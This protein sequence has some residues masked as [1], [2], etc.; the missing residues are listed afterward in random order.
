VFFLATHGALTIENFVLKVAAPLSP[1][2]LLGVRQFTEQ[3]DAS[4][5]LDKLK[6]HAER[7]WAD[8]LSGKDEAEMTARARGL[9]DEILENRR[10]GPL[11][12]DAIYKRLQRSYEAQMNHGI[13]ELVAEAKQTLKL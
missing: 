9:Q 1:A 11:V 2:L 12:L 3:M 7:L 13:A 8:A 10:G 6:E 4:I 5:R